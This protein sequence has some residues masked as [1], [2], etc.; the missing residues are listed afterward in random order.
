MLLSTVIDN[1]PLK[2]A[3]TLLVA[4]GFLWGSA[5]SGLANAQTSSAEQH[6]RRGIALMRQHDYAR[7]SEAFRAA[8]RLVPEWAAAYNAL[9]LALGHLGKL[10]EAIAAFRQAT[11]LKPDFAEAFRNLGIA[12]QRKGAF[13][14]AST[15]YRR[16][17]QLRPDDTRSRQYLVQV[18]QRLGDIPGAID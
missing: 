3:W 11:K 1:A 17:I 16:A 7:A 15:A 6:Y 13:A 10:D 18:L 14:E 5:V 8:L 4:G 9:G 12:L 2:F